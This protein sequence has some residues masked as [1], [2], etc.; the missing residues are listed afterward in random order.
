MSAGPIPSR[1]ISDWADRAG[2]DDADSQCFRAAIRAMDRVYLEWAATPEDQ[3]A[4][5]PTRSISGELIDA[6]FG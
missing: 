5:A 3:R 1:S 6:I 2:M 4:D